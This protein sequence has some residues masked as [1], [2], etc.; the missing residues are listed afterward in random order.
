MNKLDISLKNFDGI[1]FFA[2]F[3]Y[4]I[5][6]SMSMETFETGKCDIKKIKYI[7]F[8]YSFV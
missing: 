1:F 7:Y 5:M 6:H 3:M 2:F 8:L 4:A